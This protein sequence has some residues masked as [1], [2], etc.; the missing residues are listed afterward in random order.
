MTCVQ[1]R[2]QLMEWAEGLLE[3]SAAA[4]IEAHV[5]GCPTCAGEWRQMAE[6]HSRLSADGEA[7]ARVALESQVMDRILRAQTFKL[8]RISLMKRYAKPIVGLAAAAVVALAFLGTWHGSRASVVTAAE[9]MRQGIA[10][11]ESLSSVYLKVTA[12][13]PKSDNFDLIEPD[14]PMQTIEMWKEF[15]DLP[16]WRIEKGGRVV[17]MDGKSSTMLIKAA[18]GE[19]A[20]AVKGGTGA[21][22]A[23]FFKTLLDVDQVLDSE[24]KAA[25]KNGSNL[26]LTNETGAD[27]TPKLVVTIQG[28]PLQL[29]G[30]EAKHPAAVENWLKYRGITDADNRRVYRFDAQSKRLE[31]VKVYIKTEAGEV[32]ILQVAEIDYNRPVAPELFVPQ[33]PPDAVWHQEPQ[34]LPDNDTYANMSPK[35]AAQAFFQ[36]C[37]DRN[38]DEALKFMPQTSVDDSTKQYLGGLTIIKIGEPFRMGAKYFGTFVPYEIRLQNGET[39]KWNLAIRNDNKA[40]R[41]MVDGGF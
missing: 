21:G 16:K 3:A 2:E 10:A 40:K 6:M 13:N 5:A 36:A 41:W 20:Y 38:W 33:I 8:R 12:R 9:V 24:L 26:Q 30:E 23:G 39:K 31:D 35:E 29:T 32:L 22:F 27:G 18:P 7:V 37:S 17:V 11:L 34:V 19:Q 4:E 25:E 1:C 28:K 14:L 15:G